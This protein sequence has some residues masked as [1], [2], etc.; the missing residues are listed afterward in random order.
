MRKAIILLPLLIFSI[1][2][3]L[4]QEIVIPSEQVIDKIRGGLL[5]QNLGVLNGLPYEF[6]FIEQPGDVSGYVP[7]LP[8]G[9]RTDD[10]TDFEWVYIYQMQKTGQIRIPY[11]EVAQLW[12]ERINRNIWSANRYARHLMDIGIEPP[13]TG[14][15]PVN[16]WA[17]FNLSG[18]FLS[19]TFALLAPG[20]PQTASKIGLHY[21]RVAIGQESAQATQFFCSMIAAAF[22]ED[23]IREIIQWGIAALDEKSIIRDIARDVGDWQ[24]QHPDDWRKTWELIHEKYKQDTWIESYNGYGLNAAAVVAALLYGNGD[25]AKTI[26]YAFNFGWDADC[27]AATAGTILGAVKGYRWMMSQGWQIVDRYTNTTREQM[28]MDE[29]M[30]SFADRLIDLFETV[31]ERNGG[32]R[33]R[34]ED[35]LSYRIRAERSEPVARLHDNEAQYQTLVDDLREEVIENISSTDRRLQ[36]RGAYLAICLDM[37]AEVSRQDAK[38]WKKAVHALSGYWKIVNNVFY[39]SDF[40][41]LNNLASEF[42]KAGIGKPTRK[43]EDHEIY[44]DM[45]IWKEPGTWPPAHVGRITN[46]NEDDL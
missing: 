4:T 17:P 12:R 28:P 21:T 25:F 40:P 26:E 9:A 31:N 29:T 43:L 32:T 6:T 41:A 37:A 18:Q 35:V 36:A 7:S 14:Y 38:S 44:E 22:I 2:M 19:E 34:A 23:D 42:V 11:P 16:P 15:A 5:G 27:N 20:M 45:T 1:K 3:A 30:T 13:L 39:G 8:E 46:V 33:F 10:D 24:R